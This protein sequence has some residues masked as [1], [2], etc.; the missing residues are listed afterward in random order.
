[1]NDVEEAVD[2][3]LAE[4]EDKEG[5]GDM[6]QAGYTE[7]TD[8]KEELQEIKEK[9]QVYRQELEADNAPSETRLREIN[10]K[11]DQKVEKVKNASPA[12]QHAQ[13]K[14]KQNKPK[15]NNNTAPSQTAFTDPSLDPDNPF[16]PPTTANTSSQHSRHS[17][18]TTENQAGTPASHQTGSSSGNQ[19]GGGHQ[20]AGTHSGGGTGES[21][22][23]GAR[24]SQT[25]A[26][27]PS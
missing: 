21:A 24:S 14:P 9:T 27:T 7:A 11:L 15:S 4:I 19:S 26:P 6:L 16:G 18:S 3:A 22:D 2:E 17:S 5:S 25:T 10:E 23:G 8:R 20:G 12:L 13:S 1:L